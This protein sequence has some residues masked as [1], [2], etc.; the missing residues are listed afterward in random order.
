MPRTNKLTSKMDVEIGRAIAR[1]RTLKGMNQ[2]D[3]G[4]HLG[5][6]FQQVQKYERGQNRLSVS[7]LITLCRALEISPLDIIGPLIGK[8]SDV[9]K[10]AT[11]V[12]RLKR[13]LAE[14]KR[15][16]TET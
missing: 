6:T 2:T 14:I 11:D 1:V 13:K 4:E 5:V 3:L 8:P 9:S 7:S 12:E 16:A 15:I 10:W